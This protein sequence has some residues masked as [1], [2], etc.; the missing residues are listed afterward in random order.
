M[1]EH[2]N[3]VLGFVRTKLNFRER[4][5][6]KIRDKAISRAQTRI[7]LAGRRPEDFELDMLEVIV[8]EEEDNIKQNIREKGL[9]AIALALGLGWL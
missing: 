6:R 4:L 9:L 7:I 5:R 3:K 2:D 8:K 1:Q